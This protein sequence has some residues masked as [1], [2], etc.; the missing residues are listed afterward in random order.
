M[1]KCTQ[2]CKKFGVYKGKDGKFI[3]PWRSIEAKAEEL[4]DEELLRK[5]KGQ[6]RYAREANHHE[7]CWKLF[8]TK[9]SNM[10]RNDAAKKNSET[11]DPQTLAHQKAFKA[12]VNHMQKYVVQE[13]EMLLLCSLRQLYIETLEST[14]FPNQNFRSEKLKRKLEQHTISGKIKFTKAKA[15]DKGCLSYNIIF[16]ADI[17][18]E[19]AIA[20][21]YKLGRQL[22]S[23]DRKALG[24]RENT[25][26]TFKGAQG[27]PWPP[28]PED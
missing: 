21:A 13:K 27:L 5:I 17:S 15:N 18:L 22:D 16:G 7:Y 6:D 14:P 2:R 19:D 8:N 9:Y 12:V 25:L 24:F 23:S 11:T 3:E 10:K 4:G 28:T 20:E 1:S 26:E